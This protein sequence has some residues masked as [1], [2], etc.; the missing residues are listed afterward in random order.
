MLLDI[1]DYL[2][3]IHPYLSCALEVSRRSHTTFVT[4]CWY[5]LPQQLSPWWLVQ[6]GCHELIPHNILVVD[7]SGWFHM[8]GWNLWA[9]QIWR[10]W[11][12]THLVP[13]LIQHLTFFSVTVAVY[14]IKSHFF[15]LVQGK[16]INAT[17]GTFWAWGFTVWNLWGW[18]LHGVLSEVALV[19]MHFGSNQWWQV[20][21]KI[22]SESQIETT[23][24][25]GNLMHC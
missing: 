7:S 17:I 6:R 16:N 10:H 11:K 15:A 20:G 5:N 14:R 8:Q 12:C 2:S 1:V 22:L 4:F 21:T 23:K 3:C 18:H 25:A 19:Y 24:N 9:A 13:C